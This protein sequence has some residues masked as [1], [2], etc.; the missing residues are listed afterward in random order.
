MNRRGIPRTARAAGAL[1]AGVVLVGALAPAVG[2]A[3]VDLPGTGYNGPPTCQVRGADGRLRALGPGDC[4]QFGTVGQQRSDARARNVILIIG[5]GMGQQEI[6]AARNYLHGAA[7]RFPGLDNL[8]STGTYTHHSVNKDGTVSYV[9][10]SAASATAWATGTKTFNGAIGVDLDGAP[11]EN[12]LEKAQR[13]GLRTGTVTTSELQ[14]ATPAALVAHVTNRKCYGPQEEDNGKSC[15]GEAFADQYRAHGG[16]GSISE[17][18][19]DTRPDVALGGGMAAFQQMVPTAGAGVRAFPGPDGQPVTQWEAGRSVLDNAEAAGFQVVTTAEELAA[20]NEANQAR[21]LLGLFADGNM[22]PRFAPTT[23]TPGGS[24]GAPVEC[25]AQPQGTQPELVDMTTTAL[26]LLDD[27]AAEKGFFLQVESASVDKRSHAADACGAIGEVERLDEVVRAALDFAAADG[28]TLVVVTADHAHSTQILYDA[29]DTVSAT[30]RLTT[31]DGLGMTVGYGTITDEALQA[32]PPA[33]QQHTGSQ[34]RVAAFGPGE[35]NV[36]GQTDQTDLFFTIANA[37]GINDVPTIPAHA[38]APTN[39]VR[40]G[41]VNAP[42]GDVAATCYGTG[43]A[44]GPGDCAQFGPAGPLGGDAPR[45]K[46]VI[47]FIGDGTGDSELTSARNYLYGASGR[48]P[49]IDALPYTGS[50]T[51]YALA[52]DGS[53]PEYVTDSA[54]SATGWATGTKTYNGAIGVDLDGT[55]VP[56]LLELAKLRGMKTGNVTTSELQ[57][58]TPAAQGAHALHRKCYGPEEEE[59]SS[60]CQGE[61]V[62]AQWRRNGGPGSISEQLIDTR[63]DVTLGGGKKAL[64]QIVQT[65]GTFG[66]HTW[67]AGDSVLANAAAQ[68][69]QIVD[70]ASDLAAITHAD[71]DAPLLGV[72]A[73]GNL[74]R[75][76]EQ[77]IPTTTGAKDDPQHCVANPSRPADTPSLAAMTEKTLELLDGDEGFFLQVESASIDK[78]N[79][80]A[81]ICGQVGEAYQLDEAVQVAREWV[82]RTG[83]PTLIVM[84]ADHAHTSQ[85]TTPGVLTAGRTSTITTLEGD[86]M[87]INY[88]TAK[89]NDDD[90]ALGGQTHTGAQLRVAAEGPGAEAV[91]G[92]LDQTD[93]HYVLA[94]ALGITEA[95]RQRALTADGQI[96]GDALAA[97]GH[98]RNSTGTRWWLLGGLGISVLAIAAA[99]AWATRRQQARA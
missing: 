77:S 96:D 88:A 17:Q 92:Q 66:G 8:T 37:L 10:D 12:L 49:G 39:P 5:D 47:L 69:Y 62:A 91:V 41:R 7:G 32:T 35:E 52:A 1:A 57:D 58:A 65:G 89:S 18:L 38:A 34:L 51:T 22:T 59:N 14:D 72:F 6:T 63:A 95:D 19:V 26:R 99:A 11:V 28:N 81:D 97:A 94:H 85:I 3:G 93:I 36:V 78:A 74:P 55:P 82:A 61:K 84:T 71:Q 54:A 46:N 43:G 98:S 83:E 16:L 56:N 30:T 31:A 27:P 87:T 33:S 9:T 67:T 75:L 48:L 79:H 21:P 60:S 86:T 29:T 4:A 23:A 45:A 50:Y 44:P 80:D 2:A 20:V 76:L 13:A 53:G 73:D 25:V 40:A 15:R 24:A 70:N 90:V 64:E 42:R 68:G